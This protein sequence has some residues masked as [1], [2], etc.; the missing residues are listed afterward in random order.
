MG[1]P[2]GHVIG[3]APG[4][5]STAQRRRLV[6][7]FDRA[8]LSLARLVAEPCA[9]AMNVG[10]VADDAKCAVIDLGGGTLDAAVVELGDNVVQVHSVVG[11]NRLG[12]IDFDEVI[13]NRIRESL[14]KQLGPGEAAAVA[15]RE[16]ERIAVEAERAK[17]A[18]SHLREVDVVLPDLKCSD[19]DLRTLSTKV[20]QADFERGAERLGAG[21]E[22]CLRSIH[23]GE[24]VEQSG[25]RRK[26]PPAKKFT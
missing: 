1:G 22:Q 23:H 2:V 21:V 11:D 8:G 18:L 15:V 16:A 19:G 4:D 7:I 3:A 24:K 9:A 14:G 5:F 20:T 17:V 13:A 25:S 12:G 6:E 10:M 26:D